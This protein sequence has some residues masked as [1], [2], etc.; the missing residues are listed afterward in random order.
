MKCF[1][2]ESIAAICFLV[3]C[4][5]AMAEESV[6]STNWQD[7]VV[8]LFHIKAKGWE[9][10]VKKIMAL[11]DGA[12]NQIPIKIVSLNTVLVESNGNGN[13]F[14]GAWESLRAVD[15]GKAVAIDGKNR[16][17]G[18]IMSRICNLLDLKIKFFEG[19][20]VV[21]SEEQI[22]GF[23]DAYL[24]DEQLRRD[25]PQVPMD[26]MSMGVGNHRLDMIMLNSWL[27]RAAPY[28]HKTIV[29]TLTTE[30]HATISGV[31]LSVPTVLAIMAAA[32][33]KPASE[34]FII[35]DCDDK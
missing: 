10:A 5:A 19:L 24:L 26:V 9:E 28:W 3:C 2:N 8:P 32:A 34:G 14:G 1:A 33:G 21:G 17:V 35:R 18:E 29:S 6:E 30:R 23:I 16:T 15:N 13:G 22:A 27:K 31:R 11:R 25:L 4:F 20:A 12:E 7:C